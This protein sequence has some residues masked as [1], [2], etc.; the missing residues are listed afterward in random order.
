MAIGTSSE[1]TSSSL[2]GPSSVVNHAQR[3]DVTAEPSTPAA[4]PEQA[5]PVVALSALLAPAELPQFPLPI[6]A[7]VPRSDNPPIRGNRWGGLANL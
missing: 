7:I 2:A 6:I 3:V 1:G 5:A 4:V